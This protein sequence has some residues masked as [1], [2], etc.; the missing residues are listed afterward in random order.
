LRKYEAELTPAEFIVLH[1]SIGSC[2][3]WQCCY[4]LEQFKTF[5]V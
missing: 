3:C 5:I 2:A 1:S 4:Y